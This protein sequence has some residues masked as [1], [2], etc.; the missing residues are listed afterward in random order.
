MKI[1]R[2]T[3]TSQTSDILVKCLEQMS[4]YY[5]WNCASAVERLNFLLL[6]LKKVENHTHSIIRSS[7]RSLAPEDYKV[8]SLRAFNEFLAIKL[9]K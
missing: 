5:E 7:I 6:P 4:W 1:V 2:C 3:N 9:M 8:S